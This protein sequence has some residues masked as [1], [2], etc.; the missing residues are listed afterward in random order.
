MKTDK[1]RRT[2]AQRFFFRVPNIVLELGLTPYEFALY[3]AIRMTTGDDGV[4]FRS[5]VTLARLCGMSTGQVSSC[6]KRLKA[7]NEK[8]RGKPLIRIVERPSRHGGKP[9]HE[10]RVVD[11]WSENEK[12]FSNCQSSS[13]SADEV[14]TSD[15]EIATALPEIKKTPQRKLPLEEESPSLSPSPRE[16]DREPLSEISEFW[17]FLCTLF[18]RTD[19]RGPTR[20][21]KRQMIHWLPIPPEEYTLVKWW[22]SLDNRGYDWKEGIGF[23]LR[24]RP[25]SI[26]ALLRN[27]SAVNDVARHYWKRH[28]ETG[29]L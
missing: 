12:H 1:A 4:C 18:G 7:P 16:I 9:Y 6:K 8:L 21:D 11:V 23:S 26:N 22:M 3:C 28:C 29:I 5:G 20:T 10:I 14:E 24:R 27:W 2:K 15:G 25:Q 13:P 19:C 17:T